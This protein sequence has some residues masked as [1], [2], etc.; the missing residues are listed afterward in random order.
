MSYCKTCS[1]CGAA[2]DPGEVC[3]CRKDRDAEFAEI[4]KELDGEGKELLGRFCRA[5]TNTVGLDVG[6][7]FREAVKSGIIKDR[8]SLRRWHDCIDVLVAEKSAPAAATAETPS[9]AKCVTS[10]L[11]TVY[12]EDGVF[13]NE[14]GG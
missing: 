11:P 3:D 13:A 8:L 12:H 10:L 2:L 7:Q 1:E 5:L 4:L 6:A 9:D 14:I